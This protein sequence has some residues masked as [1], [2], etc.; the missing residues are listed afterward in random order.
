MPEED[1]H[2]TSNSVRRQRLTAVILAALRHTAR[3]SAHPADLAS[4]RGEA[5]RAAAA[6]EAAFRLDER[7]SLS[8]RR[9]RLSARHQS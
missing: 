5:E 8:A 3:R 2:H 4:M 6:V 9:C 1:G 7:E